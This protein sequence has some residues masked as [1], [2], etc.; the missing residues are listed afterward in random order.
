MQQIHSIKDSRFFLVSYND[1]TS[2]EAWTEGEVVRN[3]PVPLVRQLLGGRWETSRQY[4]EFAMKVFFNGERR[5]LVL[6]FKPDATE[7]D[8][9]EALRNLREGGRN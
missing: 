4:D 3:S 8:V 5:V 7:S 2:E 1:G 9:A 6:G